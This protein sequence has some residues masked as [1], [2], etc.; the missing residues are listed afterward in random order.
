MKTHK[1]ILPSEIHHWTLVYQQPLLFR[2]PRTALTASDG[3]MLD[4]YNPECKKQGIQSYP[5]GALPHPHHTQPT[6]RTMA[7][8]ADEREGI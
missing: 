1:K 4:G 7:A 6:V 2:L 5:H 3:T 8:A